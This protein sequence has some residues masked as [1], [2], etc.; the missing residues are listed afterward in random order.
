MKIATKA[1]C[2]AFLSALSP[3]A[4]TCSQDGSSGFL[5]PN[6]LSLPL[7]EKS[8]GLTYEQFT[9][10][11]DKVEDRYASIVRYYG[12]NLKIHRQWTNARVNAGTYRDGNNWHINL[13]GGF[14][15]HPAITPD[16]YAMVICHELG[17][18]IGGAPKKLRTQT[19]SWSS[20][21]GQS[22]YFAALK[23]LRT[24]FENE[25]HKY[26]IQ[27]M[28]VP[29]T[30]KEK[31]EESFDRENERNLCIRTSM[32][33][34]SVGYV[35]ADSQRK[36]RPSFDT[37][38]ENEVSQNI[39]KHPGVQCRLDTYFMGSVCEVSHEVVLS[40]R[41]EVKGTCHPSLGYREGV[42]PACWFRPNE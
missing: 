27:R 41:S 10:V 1:T 11:V 16:G 2:L 22:D 4:W 29:D 33:G 3:L 5:P 21:E 6:N 32:A 26:V 36:D 14:A 42:R 40:Q 28:Y 7:T 23:C 31:C 13:Y 19:A 35:M 8:V 18:H 38:D 37:P 25:N 20:N 34:L 17:H 12:G 15:R 9:K 30:V 24:L 39:E